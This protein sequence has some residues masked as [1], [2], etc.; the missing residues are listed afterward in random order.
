[1]CLCFVA[2]FAFD[3][4]DLDKSGNIDL[5]EAQT[6][7][8]DVYGAKFEQNVHARKTYNKL[9]ALNEKQIDLDTFK[10]FS[11]KHQA[12]LYPAFEM[13][14]R[15]QR[16]VV[17]NDFWAVYSRQRVKVFK[18][19]YVP[20]EEILAQFEGRYN[21]G[22]KYKLGSIQSTE[23]ALD[24]QYTGDKGDFQELTPAQRLQDEASRRGISVGQLEQEMK[25]HKKHVIRN[26]RTGKDIIPVSRAT[27]NNIRERDSTTSGVLEAKAR[28]KR[29]VS[30][31]QTTAVH[32]TESMGT[33]SAGRKRSSAQVLRKAGTM[34]DLMP[35]GSQR[36]LSHSPSMT[37]DG[38]EA[39][40]GGGS[41]R[42]SSVA[43]GANG[44]PS[45]KGAA[46]GVMLG[47]SGRKS[48][49]RGSV[50]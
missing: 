43:G 24:N 36:R 41:S 6:L 26:Q 1:M 11:R 25:A 48:S 4:Y 27:K 16:C 31:S 38:F 34:N 9:G 39:A 12:L 44:A 28:E 46:R 19:R 23:D 33:A 17:G 15:F 8:K 32:P 37:A 14:N 20:I 29:I 45:F 42:R 49:R 47:A 18:D 10:E 7:I 13:Q 22:E 2:V 40:S 35:T 21:V 50:M 5:D 3:L 30:R